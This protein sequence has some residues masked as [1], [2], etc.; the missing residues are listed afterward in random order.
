MDSQ[1][2]TTR[3]IRSAAPASGE[4]VTKRIRVKVPVIIGRKLNNNSLAIFYRSLATMFAAGVRIDRALNLLADQTDDPLMSEIALTLYRSVSHGAPLSHAMTSYP[5]VF[6]PMHTKLVQVGEAS[7][8][9][10]QIL[11]RL[12]Q[13]EEKRRALGMR[14]SSALTYPILLFV[15]AMVALVFIPPYLFGGLFQLIEGSGV[16]IP[17]LTRV[18]LAVSKVVSSWWFYAFCIAAGIVAFRLLPPVLRRPQ[19]NYFCTFWLQKVPVLGTALRIITVT[20]F[21]RCLEVLVSVG[22]SIDTA[23]EMSFAASANPV[24]IEKLPKTINALRSGATLAESLEEIDFFPRA[25]IQVVAVGEESGKLPTLISRLADIYDV[26]LEYALESAIAAL[27]PLM[28]MFMGIVV[29][30]VIIATMLPMM[31]V[32][33]NL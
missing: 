16:E 20:R 19:V 18:M 8:H 17:M 9:L 12:G 5:D 10:D 1:P 23:V 3:K 27:E 24:L 28:L 32:I 4:G 14:V 30:I 26:E 22:V 6:T 7:G 33:Q 25:F 29:G 21:S 11:E 15:L 31:Q 13:Y 2:L